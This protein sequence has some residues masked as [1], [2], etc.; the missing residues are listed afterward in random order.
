MKNT[1]KNLLQCFADRRE[2]CQENLTN[3]SLFGLDLKILIS[4]I[5]INILNNI[6]R[7]GIFLRK[8]SI[9]KF[10]LDILSKYLL[11]KK[12]FIAMHIAFAAIY[13]GYNL[14]LFGLDAFHIIWLEVC[15]Y[16]AYFKDAVISWPGI[17]WLF[18]FV[19]GMFSIVYGASTV[20]N[21]TEKT[22]AKSLN[23]ASTG[24][25]NALSSE[26]SELKMSHPKGGQAS[27]AC[28]ASGE[29]GNE[30]WVT[31][32]NNNKYYIAGGIFLICA[33]YISYEYWDE[34]KPMLPA[35]SL[36][37]FV[38]SMRPN[39]LR[40]P[41]W[42]WGNPQDQP[43]SPTG[44]AAANISGANTPDPDE[45]IKYI[46]NPEIIPGKS[47]SGGEE[48]SSTI[49]ITPEGSPTPRASMLQSQN[50]APATK[51]EAP[52]AAGPSTEMSEAKNISSWEPPIAGIF[53]PSSPWDE[54]MIGVIDNNVEIDL[55]SSYSKIKSLSVSDTLGKAEQFNIADLASQTTKDSL[56]IQHT[57]S[58]KLNK[59]EIVDVNG[60]THVIYD[61][62][63]NKIV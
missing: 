37:T 5:L 57:L 1:I 44:P 43:L 45:C 25:L 15:L 20:N 54:V 33:G 27:E 3:L 28:P 58:G 53:Y 51:I 6:K 62:I 31:W 9:F 30:S 59:V 32:L 34:I 18:S 47:V 19:T 21:L 13:L 14:K 60:I 41:R 12:A 4:C 42:P 22:L 38:T 36:P 24:S 46:R 7:L 8:H 2:R 52:V 49:Y 48:V 35:I 39:W 29:P 17:A 55:S 23:D 16:W 10:S 50:L 40:W 56:W 26:H 61:S 63:H 11:I